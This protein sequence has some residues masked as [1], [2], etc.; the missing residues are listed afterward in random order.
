MEQR[1]IEFTLACMI[2]SFMYENDTSSYMDVV[3][4]REENIADLAKNLH[5]RKRDIIRYLKSFLHTGNQKI[6]TVQEAKQLIVLMKGDRRLCLG[7]QRA[8]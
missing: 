6:E 7:S 2:D 1:I 3:E 4:S 5:S 8:S